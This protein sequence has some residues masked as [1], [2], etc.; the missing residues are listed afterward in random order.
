[1]IAYKCIVRGYVDGDTLDVVLLFLNITV[2][3]RLR[4]LGINCPESHSKD[5]I[6]KAKGEAARKFA[7]DLAPPSTEVRIVMNKAEGDREKYGRLIAKIVLP[8]GKD[9]GTEMIAAGHAV[10]YDG[11]KR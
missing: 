1:M 2:E 11:G 5:A 4:V 10:A 3:E 9:F 7:Y 6:E 8:N